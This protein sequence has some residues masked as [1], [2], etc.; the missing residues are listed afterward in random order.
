MFSAFGLLTKLAQDWCGVKAAA[1]LGSKFLW[2]LYF[3]L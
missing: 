1:I 3:K 2:K